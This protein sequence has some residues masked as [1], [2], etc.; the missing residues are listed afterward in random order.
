MALDRRSAGPV[1]VFTFGGRLDAVEAGPARDEIKRAIAEGR[2]LLVLD[3]SAVRYMDSSG[4]F[5]LIASF[6]HARAAGGD[7][8]LIGLSR[9]VRSVIEIARLDRVFEICED[10]AAAVAAFSAPRLG[11]AEPR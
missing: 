7:V 3:L 1:E 9:E 11:R 8:A 10:E 4:L 2:Q 6:K 5:A